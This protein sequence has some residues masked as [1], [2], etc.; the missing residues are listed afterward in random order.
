VV[1]NVIE[2]VQWSRLNWELSWQKTV[3]LEKLL[4]SVGRVYI[5]TLNSYY[6]NR[7]VGG[8]THIVWKPPHSELNGWADMRPSDILKSFLVKGLIETQSN[9]SRTFKLTVLHIE[10]LTDFFDN[11]NES[12]VMPARYTPSTLDWQNADRL[13]KAQIGKF[14]YLHGAYGETWLEL[15]LSREQQRLCVHYTSYIPS[16]S[17]SSCETA[18]TKFYLDKAEQA[19]V[20]TA[21]TNAEII[22]DH[23]N[24]ELLENEVY[25][26]EYQ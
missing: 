6:Q 4:P 14:I 26:A 20:E 21:L 22:A 24:D 12:A 17:P 5:P 11:V 19:I 25:G 3:E 16:S 13:K 2:S 9:G 7:I 8:E 10:K 23:S 15:I 1:I 18:I